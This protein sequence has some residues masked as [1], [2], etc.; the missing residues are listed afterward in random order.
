MLLRET[1]RLQVTHVLGISRQLVHPRMHRLRQTDTSPSHALRQGNLALRTYL[2]R[3]TDFDVSHP[4]HDATR[5]NIIVQT[6]FH[7]KFLTCQIT[8]L[9]GVNAHQLYLLSHT[10]YPAQAK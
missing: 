5:K 9:V 3:I 10:C 4:A 1:I 2:C 7:P 8:I 6:Y